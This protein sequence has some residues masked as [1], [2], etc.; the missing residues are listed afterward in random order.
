MKTKIDVEASVI[1]TVKPFITEIFAADD[2]DQPAMIEAYI[3]DME[4]SIGTRNPHWDDIYRGV[5][6]IMVSI[7]REAKY[8]A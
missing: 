6:D 5:R 7:Q 1:A 3:V 8:F 2:V 4:A